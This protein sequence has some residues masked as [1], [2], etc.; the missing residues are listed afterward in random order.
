MIVA[1]I[2][3][4]RA[5]APPLQMQYE[6]HQEANNAD[7]RIT[8]VLQIQF[9]PLGGKIRCAL[10]GPACVRANDTAEA[11]SRKIPP[12]RAFASRATLEAVRVAADEECGNGVADSL[13]FERSWRDDFSSRLAVPCVVSKVIAAIAAS[14]QI[15]RLMFCR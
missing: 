11:F 15:W 10:P 3:P 12:V 5:R 9:K 7:Q 4:M 8:V 6:A 2:C 1:A 13:G 14:R